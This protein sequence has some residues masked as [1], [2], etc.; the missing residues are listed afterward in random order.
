MEFVGYDIRVCVGADEGAH[1]MKVPKAFPVL[2]G[3]E[4]FFSINLRSVYSQRAQEGIYMSEQSTIDLTPVESILAE[5]A[6]QRGAVIPILQRVQDV[7][8]WLPPE[9]MRLISKRRRVPITKLYGVATFY[10][11]F[12]LAP[13]G[14][15][16]IR[17]CDGT[18]CHIKG[19]P[20]IIE[21]LTQE[22]GIQPGE[23]TPDGA[24][25]FEVVYCLGSCGLAPVAYVDQ[26]VMGRLNPEEAV[27]VARKLREE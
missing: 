8:G 4:G 2:S 25:T 16:R 13:R 3:W 21:A 11:Q 5:F 20:Q 6:D 22:L 17:V 9:A 15:H 27:A 14:R 12:Y 7:Y 1:V 10:A 23:T 19:A 18:A 26:Q 24:V